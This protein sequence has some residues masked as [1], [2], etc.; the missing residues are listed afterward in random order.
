FKVTWLTII[1]LFI[2]PEKD[3]I[4]AQNT[5]LAIEESRAWRRQDIVPAELP[6]IMQPPEE[7]IQEPMRRRRRK[8]KR[9]PQQQQEPSYQLNDD[10]TNYWQGEMEEDQDSENS[11]ITVSVNGVKGIQNINTEVW[12]NENDRSRIS[13]PNR[14]EFVQ[15]MSYRKPYVVPKKDD[16]SNVGTSASDLKNLLKN[17]GGLSLSEI[18][19]KQ[20]LSLDDLL[21]GK[22]NAY[23]VLQSTVAPTPTE[24]TKGVRRIPGV[25]RPA[26]TVSAIEH[27]NVLQL[28]KANENQP[29]RRLPSFSRT[30]PDAASPDTEDTVPTISIY[31]V[32]DEEETSAKSDNKPNIYET[33]TIANTNI[34]GSLGNRRLP[35]SNTSEK[36][37]PIKEVVSRIRPDLT[38][39]NSRR[40]L[41]PI[42]LRSSINSNTTTPANTRQDTKER[43]PPRYGNVPKL[44]ATVSPDR[45]KGMNELSHVPIEST[46]DVEV[47]L[48]TT[49]FMASTAAPISST[50]EQ[51]KE[52]VK[53]IVESSEAYEEMEATTILPLIDEDLSAD[54]E[55]KFMYSSEEDIKDILEKSQPQINSILEEF[56]L[57]NSGRKAVAAIEDLFEDAPGGEQELFQEFTSRSDKMTVTDRT[58]E[59]PKKSTNSIQKEN[60]EKR[61]KLD[62]TERN[63][64]LFYDITSL[65]TTDDKTDILELLDDRRGGSRL[66]KVLEAR[67]MS[68]EELLEHR[69][70]GSSQL[71]LAE[72]INNKTK[73]RTE[74][75]AADKLDIVAAFENFPNFNLPNVKSVKP[76][77]VRT[78]S[79]GSSYF[80]SIINIKPTDEI[81]KEGRSLKSDPSIKPVPPTNNYRPWKTINYPSQDVNFVDSIKK[82]IISSSRILPFD[83]DILQIENE[84]ARSHDFVDLELSGHG[85]K[86]NSI[87]VDN[88]S[89]P[90]AV[91][92]AI[93]ASASIVG[94]CLIIFILIFATCRW[95]QKQ[96]KKLNYTENFQTVRGRLPI[97]T[98][99][100]T[101]SS[102]TK[103]SSS[104][105]VFTTMGSRSSK[106]NTMD[107]NSP[108][109][110]EYLYDAMRKSFR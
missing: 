31:N 62:V 108:E 95:R 107:P 66:T 48:S 63:P 84:I 28:E 75:N 36:P 33:V 100:S 3:I 81:G 96:K 60:S 10:R 22:Q 50:T 104:P 11:G 76:D 6:S 58:N 25:K 12:H 87:P 35:A 97:L 73:P 61:A 68:L 20:N 15:S 110:Q 9:R 93:I 72:I 86:P 30:K 99:N 89:I 55:E 69:R 7:F 2:L 21:K 5:D 54:E 57:Y 24:A 70:R 42:K 47:I 18:L 101:A 38:N 46:T 90:V 103:R 71:H 27:P 44:G 83:D 64:S 29:T 67:N 94:V 49:T 23:K 105:N 59:L 106:L 32:K 14:N 39:S 98:R 52:I 41:L 88:A 43:L 26:S 53:D 82:D 77:D 1:V 80:T 17:S 51:H 16:G 34:R 45:T 92:S 85:F 79:D 40:R 74:V 78:D 8:R 19:Q 56:A 4:K 13:Y 102:S 109:V 37:K 91:R 65:R